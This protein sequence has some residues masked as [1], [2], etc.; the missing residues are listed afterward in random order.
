MPDAEKGRTGRMLELLILKCFVFRG[1][2][3]QDQALAVLRRALP[4]GN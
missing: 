4:I 1:L 3:E 2:D